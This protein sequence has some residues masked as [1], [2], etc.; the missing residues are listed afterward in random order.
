[1]NLVLKDLEIKKDNVSVIANQIIADVKEGRKDSIKSII[2]I[3]FVLKTLTEAKKNIIEDALT[4]VAKHGKVYEGFNYKLE[5]SNRSTYDYTNDPVW[6][7]LSNQIF[8]LDI[9]R[10]KEESFLKTLTKPI[11]V[12]T[13]EGEL[14]VRTPPIKKTTTTIKMTLK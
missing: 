10:S 12:L 2:E 4:E 11:E 7:E 6:N 3:D 14:I 1:M 13:E 5:E 8:I 9:E